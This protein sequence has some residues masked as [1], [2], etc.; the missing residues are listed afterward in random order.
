[1]RAQQ[2]ITTERIDKWREELTAEQ[3]S[4]IEWTVGRHMEAFGYRRVL[5]PPSIPAIAHGLGLVAADTV[6]ERLT[7][8]PGFWYRLLQPTKLAKEQYWMRRRAVKRAEA[9]SEGPA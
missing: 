3:V 7:Q 8:L 6:R 4:Q 1:M 5:D 9:N 2:P